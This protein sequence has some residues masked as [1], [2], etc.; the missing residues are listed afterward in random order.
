MKRRA[1]FLD[2]DGVINLEKNYVHKVE[3][4]HFIDG[5]FETCKAFQDAGYLIVVI[6]N[7]SGIGRG[8]YSEDDYKTLTEWM[9][10]EFKKR[11]VTIAG[12]YFCPHHPEEAQGDYKT[13]CSCRK[14]A[15]G[16]ILKAA[17]DLGIDI[18]S[19]VLVGDKEIDIEAGL[20]AGV[21]RNYIVRT[22]HDMGY[23]NTGAKMV[24]NS[25]KDLIE[26]EDFL[27]RE[28]SREK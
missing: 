9:K 28:T 12:A 15:P 16:M 7:Q 3:D 6:T 4:F 10:G 19:S 2:R 18:G 13:I 26:A 22:G 27:S 8:Y 20:K 17:E 5:V 23:E 11:G 25:I 21:G 1:L 24:L 14:P